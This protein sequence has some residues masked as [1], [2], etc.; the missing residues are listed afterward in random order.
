MREVERRDLKTPGEKLAIIEELLPGP[1]TF[2]ENGEIYSKTIGYAITDFDNKLVSIYPRKRRPIFPRKGS[3]IIGEV[4]NTQD[5][6][7]QV[8]ILIVDGDPVPG[9]FTGIIHISTVSSRYIRSMYEALIPGD[10]IRAKVISNQNSTAHLSTIGR[11]LGVIKAL[12][13]RCGNPLIRRGK[14]LRCPVCSNKEERKIS[15]DYG[16]EVLGEIR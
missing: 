7:A 11:S 4:S 8:R 6:T 16:K 12:C 9:E 14:L 2:I 15:L 3:T 1:G 10:I 13:L 5:K